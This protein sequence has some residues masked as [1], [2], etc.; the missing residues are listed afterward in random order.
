MTACTKARSEDVKTSGWVQDGFRTTA[1]MR[2][3][4]KQC[5]REKK[6]KKIVTQVFSPTD[7]VGSGAIF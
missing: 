1:D 5:V 2:V 3:V 6:L 4:W 7:W